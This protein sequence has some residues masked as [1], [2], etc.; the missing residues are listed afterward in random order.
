MLLA[1]KNRQINMQV[2]NDVNNITSAFN[3]TTE[4][5]N[6]LNDSLDTTAYTLKESKQNDI[7]Q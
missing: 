1:L 7:V 4:N 2:N 5:P 3:F 6:W